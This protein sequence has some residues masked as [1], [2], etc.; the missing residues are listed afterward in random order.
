MF[1]MQIDIFH[2]DFSIK[3][4][5][6]AQQFPVKDKTGGGGMIL[7]PSNKKHKTPSNKLNKKCSQPS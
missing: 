1:Y 3:Y 7:L 6:I 2:N 5:L 4:F